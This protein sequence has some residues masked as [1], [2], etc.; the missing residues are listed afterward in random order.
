MN[1]WI[2]PR[3]DSITLVEGITG[4]D[5]QLPGREL[6]DLISFTLVT[7]VWVMYGQLLSITFL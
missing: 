1:E 6:L 3:R 7:R 5:S 4:L 2:I